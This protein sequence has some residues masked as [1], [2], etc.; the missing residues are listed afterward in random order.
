MNELDNTVIELQNY[1]NH[2]G[3]SDYETYLKTN[4]LLSLQTKFAE[5]CNPDELQF[6]LVH[7]TEEL[8][9][10]LINSSLIEIYKL[11]DE[12]NVH[13]IQTYFL[14]IHK[15]QQNLISVIQLLHTMSPR[16]YQDIR[17]KLGNGSGQESPGFNAFLKIVPIVWKKFKKTFYLENNGELEK[18]YNQNY[19]HCDRYVM[20]ESFL[21]L[22]DLYNK[23]LYYHMKLVGRSIGLNAHSLKGNIVSSM[24][25][26]ITRSFVSELLDIRSNMTSQWGNE[27]GV[28]RS[29]LSK[30]N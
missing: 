29:T 20:C 7:Q 13:R 2:Q 1:L 17:T 16:A 11:I 23:F 10:K 21:E 14:R 19:S 27:Y 9:F 5:L 3:C 15:A 28:K 24:T 6:Q 12:K 26:R 25:Q 8:L 4:D 22:D 30:A 18:I